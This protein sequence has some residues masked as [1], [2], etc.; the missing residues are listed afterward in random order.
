[1]HPIIKVVTSSVHNL[2]NDGREQSI[3]WISAFLPFGIARRIQAIKQFDMDVE[4]T[5]ASMK[6]SD[7]AIISLAG[8]K[9]GEWT[10]HYVDFYLMCR[11]EFGRTPEVDKTRICERIFRPFGLTP[12]SSARNAIRVSLLRHR[13]Q[14]PC[15][16]QA[17]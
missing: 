1:L 5:I 12:L 14:F 10:Y 8:F 11:F 2:H 4:T 15:H 6:D 13:F 17:P 9:T 3:A 16:W 7:P